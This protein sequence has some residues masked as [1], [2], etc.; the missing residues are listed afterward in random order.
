MADKNITI[1]QLNSDE[2]YDK[3]YPTTIAE[4]LKLSANTS[5]LFGTSIKDADAAMGV[6]RPTC[7]FEICNN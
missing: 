6:M 1:R 7:R 2:N 5:A 3:L 4:Q